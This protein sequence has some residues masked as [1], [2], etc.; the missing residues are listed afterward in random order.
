MRVL[1]KI[2]PSPVGPLTLVSDGAALTG[3]WT[4]KN[5]PV[6]GEIAELPVFELTE[7]WLDVYFSGRE[8]DFT[9]PLRMEGTPFRLRVWELLRE[10]PYGSLTSYGAIAEKLR[11]AG[12]KASPRAVGGA[13]GANPVS[14]IVPCHRVIGSDG[15]LTGYAGGIETKKALLRLEGSYK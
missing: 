4:E 12:I 10:I 15:S 5:A 11:A 14:I 9:P 7:K 2:A 3:L 1:Y 8:P 13:V 6:P